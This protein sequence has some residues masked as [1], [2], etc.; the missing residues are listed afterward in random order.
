[1]FGAVFNCV[2]CWVADCCCVLVGFRFCWCDLLFRVLS[3]VCVVD[4][5]I[6]VYFV[7]L[8]GGLCVDLVA[9]VTLVGWVFVLDLWTCFLILVIWIG[10]SVVWL[11]A[12]VLV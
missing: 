3:I 8:L 10:C 11:V 1:M 2:V 6:C 4:F 5:V 12:T 7:S 9:L